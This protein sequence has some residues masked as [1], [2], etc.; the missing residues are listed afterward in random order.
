MSSQIGTV[1]DLVTGSI[2]RKD[3]IADPVMWNAICDAMD[4]VGDA[5]DLPGKLSA[6]NVLRAQFDMPPIT[7]ASCIADLDDGLVPVVDHLEG[8]KA[9]AHRAFARV[10]VPDSSSV[11]SNTSWRSSARLGLGEVETSSPGPHCRPVANISPRY[12]TV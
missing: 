4:Q 2:V 1:R 12:A 3:L 9:S 7:S 10:P 5:P 8:V 6:V 11:V